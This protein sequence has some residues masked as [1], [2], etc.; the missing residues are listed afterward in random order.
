M[1]PNIMTLDKLNKKEKENKK[2]NA[3]P[4]S[5]PDGYL[6]WGAKGIGTFIGGILLAVAADKAKDKLGSL[7]STKDKDDYEKFEY[8][9]KKD[10]FF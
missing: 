8:I 10:G 4:E 7:I 5:K 9:L 2:I 3:K 6:W 1:N